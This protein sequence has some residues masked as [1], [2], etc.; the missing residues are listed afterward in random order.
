MV[1]LA[2]PLL[3]LT[4]AELMSHPVV[5]VP[6]QMSLCGAAHLL[7]QANVSGAPVVDDGGRCIGVLSSTDFLH[8]AE[9]GKCAGHA[10]AHTEIPVRSWQIIE[11][12]ADAHECVADVMNYDPVTVPPDTH[13]GTIARMMIDAHIHRVI[14]V[15]EDDRPIG[16][17]SSTDVLGA[18]AHAQE[19]S[20]P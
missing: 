2:Q 1:T 15:D 19:R 9:E 11:D 4:A 14:V 18:V 3:S 16:V 20:T 17:V 5:L 7:G 13:I 8:L 6:K 12:D 10:K